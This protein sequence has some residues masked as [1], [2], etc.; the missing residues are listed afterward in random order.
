MLIAKDRIALYTGLSARSGL[1]CS[2]TSAKRIERNVI[3]PPYIKLRR[4]GRPPFP[5]CRSTLL[6][7]VGQ[8]SGWS[9]GFWQHAVSLYDNAAYRQNQTCVAMENPSSIVGSGMD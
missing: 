3:K 2:I 8:R 5:P 4:N 7:R 9:G 1:S 6:P